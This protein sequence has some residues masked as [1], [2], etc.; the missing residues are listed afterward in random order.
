[1]GII[2]KIGIPVA[3]VG[4]IVLLYFFN[5]EKT[6]GF[7]QCPFHLLTGYDCP[8]C[9]TQRAF[10]CLLHWNIPEALHYNLFLVVSMPY[11]FALSAVTWFDPK[12][13]LTKIKNVC[14]N[15]VTVN[16]YVVMLILWWIIRNIIR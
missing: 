3:C 16:I 2:K 15:P 7:P 9:G 4:G 14:Y 10:H 6:I 11:A 8:A 5:P 1:M 12:G 13:K